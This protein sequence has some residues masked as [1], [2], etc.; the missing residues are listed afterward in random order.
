MPRPM[1]DS[2]AFVDL[3]GAL[4]KQRVVVQEHHRKGIDGSAFT[5]FGKKAPPSR[6]IGRIDVND[7]AAAE[8]MR[9]TLYDKQGTK[10][11]LVDEAGTSHDD[12]VVEDVREL[13][14]DPIT[15]AVGGEQSDPDFMMTWEFMLRATDL[16]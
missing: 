1:L 15:K 6:F 14:T 11:T 9:G 10:V 3:K 12:V 2:Q 5:R 16:T 7:A 4:Q 13:A 8:T